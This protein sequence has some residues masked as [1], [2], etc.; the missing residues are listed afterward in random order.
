MDTYEEQKRNE[1]HKRM[2]EAPVERLILA[3][4]VPTIISMLVSSF[5]NMVDSVLSRCPT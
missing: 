1:K 4:S 3:M 5:Y 2:T